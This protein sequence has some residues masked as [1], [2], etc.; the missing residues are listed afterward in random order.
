VDLL[1]ALLRRLSL[2]VLGYLGVVVGGLL[3]LEELTET[4]YEQGGFFFDEPILAWF[5]GLITPPLTAFMRVLS[6][7]G[8]VPVMLGLS[9]LGFALL[10]RFARREA[11]FFALSMGGAS[12]IMLLGKMVLARPRPTLYD[13]QLWEV[14]SASF[15][16]GHATGSAAFF[17]SLYFLTARL[18]PRW[19]LP[20]ALLGG[21]AALL[22]SA[23]RLYLQVHYPSDILAGIA[24]GAAWVMGV[25]AA[26]RY[27]TRDRSQRTVLLTLSADVVAR[28]RE[29]A[30]RAGLSEDAAADAALRAHYGLAPEGPREPSQRP[31]LES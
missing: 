15:S 21:L 5:Y 17:L 26:Y 7:V 30:A 20:V 28:Y 10:L 11:L 27:H 8:D 12:I 29:D 31:A 3:L 22:I 25:N 6:T 16:S 14:G 2:P 24:L 4:I 1:R 18:A 19:R 9:L 23:S 13:V